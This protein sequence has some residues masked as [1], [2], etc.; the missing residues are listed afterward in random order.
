MMTLNQIKNV[1]VTWFENHGQ[2]TSVYYCDDFDF[3]A[4]RN[5]RY[6]TV[7]IEYLNSAISNTTT[8]HNYKF[9]IADLVIG[10]SNDQQDEIHSDCL[11]IAEDFFT[12]LQNQDD[13]EFFFNLSSSITPFKNDTGDRT[14]GIVFTLQISTIRRQNICDKP[15]K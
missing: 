9:V 3:N 15:Q 14:A 13:E 10:D 11:S 4:E 1:L 6:K 7:N 8:N 5:I 2:I 12:Y